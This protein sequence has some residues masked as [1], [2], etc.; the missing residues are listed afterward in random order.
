MYYVYDSYLTPPQEWA[1]LLQPNG[2]LSVRG[3]EVDGVFLGLW[4]NSDDGDRLIHPAGFDGFYTYF[5]SE[6]TS[7]AANTASWLALGQWARQRGLLFVPSVAPGYNDTR[8]RPWNGAASRSRDYGNRCV[9]ICF[10]VA[11]HIC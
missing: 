8:I 10:S 6:A 11:T 7:F 2:S 9:Y 3:T 1:Q 5:A 4:L